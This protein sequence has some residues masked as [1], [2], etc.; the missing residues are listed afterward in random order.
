MHYKNDKI[1]IFCFAE[2][3]FNNSLKELKEHLVFNLSF[4]QDNTVNE[5]LNEFDGI[6]IHEKILKK[7]SM[8]KSLKKINSTKILI[9]KSEFS[10]DL[11]YDEKI[12]N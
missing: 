7:N 10:A 2:E 3:D 5:E 12:K 1:D 9:S 8:L 6:L 4:S 11:E